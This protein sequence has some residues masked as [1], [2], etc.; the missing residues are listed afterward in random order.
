MATLGAMSSGEGIIT[1]KKYK[2]TFEGKEYTLTAKDYTLK[3]SGS[4]T[5]KAYRCLGNITHFKSSWGKTI[6]H[7]TSANTGESFLLMLDFG[8]NCALYTATAGTYTV[9]AIEV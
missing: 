7:S 4:V 9:S 2:V 8:I 1:G 6:S 5:I 3:G